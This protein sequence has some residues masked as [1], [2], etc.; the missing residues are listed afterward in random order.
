M[1]GPQP[2]TGQGK[3]QDMQHVSTSEEEA[4]V[5]FDHT[6]SSSMIKTTTN[7][8]DTSL[9]KDHNHHYCG[10]HASSILKVLN[11]QRQT[12]KYTDV[13]L[14][15]QG[16]TFPC[17]KAVLAASSQYFQEQFDANS[18]SNS[19]K[20]EEQEN[21][22]VGLEDIEP[23][24][25]RMSEYLEVE[26]NSVHPLA[27]KAIIDFVY[28][29]CIDVSIESAPDLLSA[30]TDLIYPGIV[31]ACCEVLQNSLSAAT[32]L[33]TSKLAQKY[34]CRNLH[35]QAWEY[36]LGNF[37]NVMM[38]DTFLE[39][40]LEQ[41]E[42][43]IADENLRVKCEDEVFQ[44]VLKWAKYDEVQRS[45]FLPKLLKY[46]RLPLLSNNLIQDTLQNNSI[47]KASHECIELLKDADNL[48]DLAKKE[49][50]LGR[51]KLIPRP[52]TYTEVLAVIG[53]MKTDR[54]WSRD[55]VY[56]DP[57]QQ[58][59]NCLTELPF[60]TTDYSVSALG[61][62]IYIT[63]GYKKDSEDA[64][65]EVWKFD[66]LGEQWIELNNLNVPRFNHTSTTLD[67]CLY[68]IGGEND[69]SGI[70]ELEMYN[71]DT[72]SW[73]ILGETNEME[74]N[75]TA[76]GI[77]NKLF[78][79]GWLVHPRQTCVTQC[80]DLQTK[81][82]LVLPCSGLN[83][84]IFPTVLLSGSIYLLGASRIKEVS[85]YNPTTYQLAKVEPM[86]YK[87]NSPSAAVVG[88]KIY[89]TGG[90]L[91]HHLDKG[92]VFDPNTGLWT[93][94]PPM[95]SGLCFHGS[96]GVLKYLG[97]PFFEPL[98]LNNMKS[99]SLGAMGDACSDDTGEAHN[100]AEEH[101]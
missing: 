52:S 13:I 72:N 1:E 9:A 19:G 3:A 35:Q 46:I 16:A 41:L 8:N 40:S 57:S 47:I 36:A 53:G 76:A 67:G 78:I 24:L 63:G 4:A 85:K 54:S 71:P 56:Y 69:N 5:D 44:A 12:G 10:S 60:Q 30:A 79:T 33:P 101:M 51:V 2:N 66:T 88:G 90:E 99:L 73:E 95:P 61:T 34:N 93:A 17:H 21:G 82:C 23:V 75:I 94:I 29:A 38:E 7:K 22:S 27:L 55:I 58:E 45:T 32:C 96:V 84:Q 11:Q 43:Y 15:S 64:T 48:K 37:H 98:S 65:G 6:G 70:T 77:D 100:T 20:D 62:S 89:V 97:P 31:T 49:K 39:M 87:R 50:Q 68:V 74:S 80:F 92:E 14:S 26:V 18:N 59:W 25:G 83:R 42:E 28:T 91:R 81:E 86:R